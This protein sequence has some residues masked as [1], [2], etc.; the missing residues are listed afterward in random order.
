MASIYVTY[1]TLMVIFN[2]HSA[3]VL[4]NREFALKNKAVGARSVLS[5]YDKLK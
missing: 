1:D 4:R 5:N 3:S 2:K